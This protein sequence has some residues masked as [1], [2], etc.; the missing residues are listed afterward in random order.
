[1][2]KNIMWDFA[3]VVLHTIKGSFNSLLAERLGVTIGEIERLINSPTN[4]QWDINEIDDLTFYY[5]LLDEL[6]QP[7]DKLSIIQRFVVKD[8]YVDNEIL[9]YIKS[10]RKHYITVLLTN[11]PAHIHD[12]MRTDWIVDG[13][14]DHMIASCDVKL[15]KPDPKIYTLALDRAG[16]APEES[17][18]IDDREVNV[19]AAEALGIHA[20]LF[21]NKRQIMSA[22]DALLAR[23]TTR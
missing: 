12:F 18:F 9:A 11:F 15:I 14:F 7:R 20:I 5:Y 3:G 21:E 23:Q 6:G 10:L 4:D 16:V 22:L 2:I 19:K 13:A 17:V 1:M 8:F